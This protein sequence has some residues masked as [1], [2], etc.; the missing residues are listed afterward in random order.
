MV[1]NDYAKYYDLFYKDK[2][3]EVET[4]Y[5]DKLI[6]KYSNKKSK[7]ILDIGC[8][9]GLHDFYFSKKEYQITGIDI[10][11]EMIKRAEKKNINNAKFLVGDATEFCLNQK[12]DA[13]I[14][15][16]HV[17][18]YQTRNDKFLGIVKSA[19]AHLKENGLFVFDFWYGPAVLNELPENRIKKYSDDSVELTRF[20]KPTL[21]INDNVVEVEYELFIENLAENKMNKVLERH[22]MR[23]YFKPEIDLVLNNFDLMPLKY[24]EWL[25]GN[26]ISNRTWGVCC[27]AKKI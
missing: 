11:P 21:K 19:S 20:A 8:G 3:Y 25:S 7:S 15:L 14:S 16:F 9:T 10:S 23:Y 24:E 17:L 22:K 1:F 18:S 6:Q 5:V 12:Y 13:V 2:N 27:I 26:E 4:E